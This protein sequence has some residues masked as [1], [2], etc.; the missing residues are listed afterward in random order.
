MKELRYIS[1]QVGLVY[2]R[3]CEIEGLLDETGKLIE[4]GELIQAIQV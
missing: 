3:G 2:I 4:E 1:L